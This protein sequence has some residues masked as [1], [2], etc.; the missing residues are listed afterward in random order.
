ML[1]RGFL[2]AGGLAL[3]GCVGQP[4]AQ[5]LVDPPVSQLRLRS[6]VSSI[7]VRDVSLPRYASGD[8]I[9]LQGTDGA[10]R[11]LRKTAWADVPQRAVS[12]TLARNLAA[13][14]NIR[15]ST[16]PWPFAD[17]P[18]VE[19]AVTADRFLVG[20][21]G[22]L[23]FSGLYA[24]APRNSDLSDRSGPFSIEVPV[25]GGSENLNG[26]AAAHGT[27]LVQLSETIARRL[28]R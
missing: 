19:V 11:S 13:I 23:R 21:D 12:L 22:I 6:F 28:G 16:E 3:A 17:P 24:I 9:A 14:L 27:A 8:E 18:A 4:V 5:Y 26:V 10:V 7:E 1:R 20:S 15:V 25:L 2:V